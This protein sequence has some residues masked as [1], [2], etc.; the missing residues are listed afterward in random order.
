[1]LLVAFVV[2]QF[3]QDRPMLNTADFRKPAFNGAM[4]ASFAVAGSMFALILYIVLYLQNQLG[5]N[6]FEGGL[7]TTPIT[8]G[9][10]LSSTLAGRLTTV[11]P[12]RAMIGGGFGLIGIGLLL[13]RGITADSAWTHLIPGMICCGVGAGFVN[14]PLVSTVVRVVGPARA[15]MSGGLNNTLRQVGLA[16]GIA[17]YGSI[18]AT[19]LRSGTLTAL[20]GTPFAADAGRIAAGVSA[21]ARPGTVPPEVA[22]AIRTGFTGALDQVLLIG[23][24][25]ALAGCVL[26]AVL[27]R[28]K[29]FVPMGPPPGAA[30]KPAG[31]KAEAQPA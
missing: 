3:R 27:I 15:G 26:S 1:V 8:L 9:V 31:A 20:Q 7:R 2:S 4:F 30:P 28:A 29:D 5:Y 14:V 25:L 10:F 12:S 24:I 21:G 13:M 19:S 17:L 16:T 22:T 6:A 11:L 23:A 18:F